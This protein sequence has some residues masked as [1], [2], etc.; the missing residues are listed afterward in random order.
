MTVAFLW[1][2]TSSQQ[3]ITSK[4]STCDSHQTI[5]LSSAELKSFYV[6]LSFNTFEVVKKTVANWR[7]VAPLPFHILLSSSAATIWLSHIQHVQ[8]CTVGAASVGPNSIGQLRRK[9][10]LTCLQNCSSEDE[11]ASLIANVYRFYATNICV[12]FGKLMSKCKYWGF[13]NQV[14]SFR[15]QWNC[16]N[17]W[18]DLLF[19]IVDTMQHT[20]PCHA[21]TVT[22]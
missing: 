18:V 2:P 21:T 14:S 6:C 9:P 8:T 22:V 7:N 15:R 4:R 5:L 3:V 12:M 1:R 10:N 17:T 16:Y 13:A 20:E 11:Y 19:Q